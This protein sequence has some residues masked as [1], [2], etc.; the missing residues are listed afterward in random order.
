MKFTAD[1]GT[2]STHPSGDVSDL[3]AHE[4]TSFRDE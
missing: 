2:D 3:L 4:S 1:G